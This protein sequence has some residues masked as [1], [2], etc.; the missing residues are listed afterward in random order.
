MTAIPGSLG[1]PLFGAAAQT[2]EF[3]QGWEAYFLS[4]QAKH[5]GVFRVNIG[6][7]AIALLD[8]TAVA[9]AL[10]ASKVRKRYGF[11]PRKPP[12]ELVGNIVPIMFTNDE[13]HTRLKTFALNLL[14]RKAG[15][16]DAAFSAAADPAFARWEKL[17]RFDAAEE[18]EGML[19]DLVFSWWFGFRADAADLRIWVNDLLA[20]RFLPWRTAN[21][22][23]MAEA[24]GRLLAQVEASPGFAE[25]AASA[26]ADAGLDAASAARHLLFI[27]GFNAWSGLRGLLASYIAEAALHPEIARGNESVR[28]AHVVLEVL[29]L[30]PPAPIVFGEARHAFTLTTDNGAVDVAEGELLMSV[31]SLAQRDPAVLADGT[32]FRPER[33]LDPTL[34]RRCV[35]WSGGPEGAETTTAN[36]VC[37][38]RD[39]VPAIAR[40]FA[41]RWSGYDVTLATPPAWS[42]VKMLQANRPETR[43]DVVGFRR[44]T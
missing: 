7:P 36:K 22:R 29:R 13:E 20:P 11:G 14:R 10:D 17:D 28:T 2:I 1:L 9:A 23:R 38:G 12:P 35:F 44:R 16:L 34:A 27:A 3:L 19:A 30:H 40:S 21:D 39:V 24:Y 41:D 31:L 42:R 4:R 8:S 32:A 18:I 26:H 25:L 43:L 37:P 15:T 5:G 6:G 33:F